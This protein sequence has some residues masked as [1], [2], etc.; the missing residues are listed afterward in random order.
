MGKQQGLQLAWGAG[1]DRPGGLLRG[2]GEGREAPVSSSMV[3]DWRASRKLQGASICF[4]TSPSTS[5]ST[6]GVSKPGLGLLYGRK[7]VKSLE[8]AGALVHGGLE[9]AHVLSMASSCGEGLLLGSLKAGA[10][11]SAGG[12]WQRER[13]TGWDCKLEG[14]CRGEGQGGAAAGVQLQ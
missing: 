6:R 8:A 12:G 9:G 10:V 1:L 13:R 14:S 3:G 7:W 11:S 2:G 5:T 4:S